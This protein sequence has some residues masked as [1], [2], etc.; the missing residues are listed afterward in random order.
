METTPETVTIPEKF[1]VWG[2]AMDAMDYVWR[3]R[4]LVLRFGWIALAVGIAGAWLL[5]Y[6][7][8]AEAEPSVELFTIAIIQVLI[9]LAPT[10]TWYRIVA[11]GE[12]EAARRPIFTLGRLEFRLLLWQILF[13][14]ALV[15]PFA[16]IGAII[17]SIVG[18]VQATL[19]QIAAIA[20]GAPLAIAGVIAFAVIGTRLSMV[21]ALSTL[22]TPTGFKRAWALTRSIAWRL[23]GSTIVI[24]LAIVV[25][26][27]FAELIA[28]LVGMIAAIAFSVTSGDVLPYVRAVA[29]AA[30]NLGGLFAIAT[31]FGFVYRARERVLEPT[32]EA[33]VTPA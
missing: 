4:V 18:L 23:T 19:G 12:A 6:W 9:M 3:H 14:F 17:G 8:V 5:E 16:V 21:V 7:G 27:A 24:I 20:V 29:Q 31:L 1:P 25:F 33:P 11:Y 22:D 15:V 28:W 10:V 30:I 2:T 26:L 32:P 13:I